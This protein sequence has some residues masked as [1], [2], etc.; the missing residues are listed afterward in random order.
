MKKI[1]LTQG[2][3]ALVDDE[4]FEYLNQFKWYAQKDYDTFYANRKIRVEQGQ[5]TAVMHRVILDVTDHNIKVDHID[6]NGLNNQ[7][8]N[9]RLASSSQNSMNR[10]STKNTS[11]KYKG[12][13][14]RRLNKWEASIYLS[15]KYKYIGMFS[16]E[17]E[18][19]KAYDEMAKL[20]FGEFACLNFKD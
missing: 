18:A 12:V 15:K 2:Q 8:I 6:H 11:S 17:I 16:T 1:P 9:L 19:A 14:Y 4:D 10:K 20:H 7:K 3:F 13:T 5:K